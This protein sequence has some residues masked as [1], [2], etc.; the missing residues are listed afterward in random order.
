[1]TD[2]AFTDNADKTATDSSGLL[3]RVLLI[4]QEMLDLARKDQW[5]LV[6]SKERDRTVLLADCFADPVPTGQS[7]LFSE[8]L[9]AMLHM[10]EEMIGLLEAAKEN[11]AVKRTD[12]SH[13]KRSLSHY[14]DIEKSH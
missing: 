2:D 11:V 9:A 7:Q 8:A 6:T 10:N 14:L 4:T 13:K 12:Q 5:D 1:M 3:A